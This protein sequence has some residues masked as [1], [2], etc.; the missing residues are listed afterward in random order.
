MIR[1]PPRAKRTDTLFPYTTLFRSRPQRLAA[2]ENAGALDE[3]PELADVARPVVPH[4]QRKR[5]FVEAAFGVGGH[6]TLKM[7][8]E[9]GDVLDAIGEAGNLEHDHAEAEE[10]VFAEFAVGDRSAKILMRRRDDAHIDLAHLAAADADDR[11]VFE[12]R[13]EAHTSEL[14]SL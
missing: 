11:P 6:V 8:D 2:V 14:Q 9:R 10:Q 7:A 12:H 3:I 5:G 1:R 13:S 4:Q